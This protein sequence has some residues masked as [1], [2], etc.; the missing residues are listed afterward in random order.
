MLFKIRNILFCVLV[1]ASSA[2][3]DS[4]SEKPDIDFYA[5]PLV[6]DAEDPQEY[7]SG[8][9]T[10][11]NGVFAFAVSGKKYPVDI[12]NYRVKLSGGERVLC[13]I[14]DGRAGVLDYD[15]RGPIALLIFLFATG[16]IALKAASGA[17]ALAALSFAMFLVFGIYVPAILKGA[18]PVASAILLCS[19]IALVTLYAV[20]GR[21]A[22]APA[23]FAGA[24]FGILSAAL[25]A[26]VFLAVLKTRGFSDEQIQLLNYLARALKIPPSDAGSVFLAGIVIAASGVIMDVAITISSSLSSIQSVNSAIT[27]KNLFRRGMNIG[28]DVIASMSGS[29]LF[30]YAGGALFLI[31]S[32]SFFTYSAS[33][34][35]NAEWFAALIAG[36]FA[37]TCGMILTVPVT[38]FAAA[39]LLTKQ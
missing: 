25:V 15:R 39:F 34:L 28:G 23:A 6:E 35:L 10:M 32:R 17:R 5:H 36:I 29:L 26:Y 38:A 31:V 3:A 20:G 13:V 21:G 7:R 18:P 30:A 9:I 37:G 19:V 12:Y 33:F 24:L 22:K 14:E 11:E 16:V 1:A 4:W 2:F 8:R 27:R